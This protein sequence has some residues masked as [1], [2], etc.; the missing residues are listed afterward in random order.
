MQIKRTDELNTIKDRLKQY[1]V[2]AILGP[3]QVGKTTLANLIPADHRFD[4]ENHEDLIQLDNAQ[5]TLENL[6][7]TI[8]IDEIQKKPDLFPLIR[9]LVDYDKKK[10]FLILGSASRDLIKQSSESLAGRISYFELSGFKLKD[11][12]KKVE[13]LWLRGGLPPSFLAKSD[14]ASFQWRKDY[15]KTFL[16]RD[17]P[18][19]GIRVPSSTLDRFW[20]MLS[21]YHGQIMNFSEL[22]RSFGVSDVTVRNYNDI[23]EGTFVI[24]VLMPW[25]T[26]VKKRLVKRPKIYLRDSGIFHNLLSIEDKKQLM[27]NPKLGASWEGFAMECLL[28]RSSKANNEFYFWATHTGAEVDLFYQKKGKNWG[29]EFKYGDAPRLTPSMQSALK[30]LDLAHLYVVY[31]GKKSYQLDKKVSVVPLQKIE[32]IEI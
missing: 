3:R 6:S 22:S 12:K 30:D 24:R 25:H 11:A 20:R 10:R 26:N 8:V 9:Y 5:T 16:E 31:P 23:L 32:E 4:L 18:E 19:L 28:K 17:V 21:H 15:M 2:V 29:V 14:K 13:P 27:Q 1:P 7:G